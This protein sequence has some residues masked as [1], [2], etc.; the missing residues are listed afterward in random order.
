[1]RVNIRIVLVGKYNEG[2][3]KKRK[4]NEEHKSV[5]LYVELVC[6]VGVINSF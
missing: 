3:G 2:N 6:A 5:T 1:M 4:K